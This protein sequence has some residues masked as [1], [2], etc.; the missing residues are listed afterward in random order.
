MVLARRGNITHQ[1]E[2]RMDAQPVTALRVLLLG[3]TV[4]MESTKIQLG[5]IQMDVLHVH[6]YNVHN[7]LLDASVQM[8]NMKM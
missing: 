2:A 8:D 1:L 7:Y 3:A 5:E 6:A 4:E